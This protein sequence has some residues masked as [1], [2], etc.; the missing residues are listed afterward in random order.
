MNELSSKPDFSAAFMAAS[1]QE[2]HNNMRDVATHVTNHIQFAITIATAV[3]AGGVLLVGS[4]PQSRDIAS[5]VCLGGLVMFLTG[6]FTFVR[7]VSLKSQTALHIAR[8]ECW[9]QY[10]I[11]LD[12]KLDP[13][14]PN[15]DQIIEDKFN[16]QKIPFTKDFR[17]FTHLLAIF[18]GIVL[19]L[20]VLGFCVLVYLVGSNITQGELPAPGILLC[21]VFLIAGTILI[22]LESIEYFRR[23]GTRTLAAVNEII[24]NVRERNAPA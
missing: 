13:Y 24:E 14:F 21:L 22:Y 16:E 6:F 9:S 15:R 8:A 18:N 20:S 3:L 23:R 5:I 2:A 4:H 12:T 17:R 19:S 10:F 1:Y 11:D 7:L